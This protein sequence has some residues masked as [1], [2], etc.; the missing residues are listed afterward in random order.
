MPLIRQL[1]AFNAYSEGWALYAQQL[2]A[3]LGAYDDDPVGR[4]GYLQ[5]IAFRACRL[6][7]DTG[8]H[9][10]RWTREQGVKFFVDVNGSN[11]LEVASEVDRYCSWPG[12]ACGYKVGHSEINRQ[13]EKAK[14]AL[15]AKY[16]LKAF[17]DTVV[18][19]G[20][21]PLDVLAKNVDEYIRSAKAYRYVPAPR[22]P[23]RMQP[24][25]IWE[26][27]HDPVDLDQAALA[28]ASGR[29]AA[30]QRLRNR[31]RPSRSAESK[32]PN[33]LRVDPVRGSTPPAV[34]SIVLRLPCPL[35]DERPG[36]PARASVRAHD[37]KGSENVG[38]EHFTLIFNS[39]GNM[40]GTTNKDRHSTFETLPAN[41]LD[42]GIF[43]EAIACGSLEITKAN[44]DNQRN[45]VQEE[46][47]QGL[48]NQPYGRSEELIDELA[49]DNAAYK[50]SVIGSMADLNAASVEGR[51][52]VLQD[53][54]RPEQRRARDRRR[55]RF[56][57]DAREGAHRLRAIPAQPQP[58]AMDMTEPVQTAERR[59]RVDDPLA[60][61]SR[62]DL[63]FK[64][65]P[66]TSE[67]DDA[68]RV[69]ATILSSGRSS[70]FFQKIVREQQLASNVFAGRDPSVATGL[71]GISATVAPGK[72]PEAVEAAVL[73]EIERIKTGPIEGWEIEKAQ[74]NAK[75]AVVGGLTS[76]LQRGTQL[77]EFA[78]V[79]N[80]TGRVNQRA[81]RIMKVT[82]ADVQ[83]VAAKYLTAANRTVVVTVP[84]PAAKGG[85]Q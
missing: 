27:A 60:R 44:L 57:A 5:A 8:I 25:F 73:A 31:L 40:N 45:A 55:H 50:H 22:Q 65:P 63:A 17:D 68:V 2:A 11:P 47:R 37:V 80:D 48:D 20:N 75:R 46:R 77:A 35:A 42:L 81:E 3:E 13:R 16:D 39:G 79:F 66:R 83:R 14:S 64:V 54:L 9:A 19:G 10:K 41:Q 59:Q 78:A 62:V 15:G 34:Y 38:H 61:L 32:L 36:R 82:A 52:V 24:H 56:K 1:L 26:H 4:L 53:L 69:L 28:S 76:S 29:A 6:V 49:Y 21:V 51:G 84:K 85:A 33:G 70:R 72:T 67:E 43:L 58:P 7:V 12:Q 74:N 18:L 71:F 30:T 23:C